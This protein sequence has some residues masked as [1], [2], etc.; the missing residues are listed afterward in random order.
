MIVI[1]FA[2]KGVDISQPCNEFSC[3]KSSYAVDFSITR[4]WL[5]TGYFD[6]A[7][8]TNLNNAKAAGI[9]YND[10]YMFPCRGKSAATQVDDMIADL[11]KGLNGESLNI[12]MPSNDMI[13][14]RGMRAGYTPQQKKDKV[15]L[16]SNNKLVINMTELNNN[17][18]KE[19][20]EWRKGQKGATYGMIWFDIEVNPSSGCG[21]GTSYSSNC[22]Y[23]QQL[24]EAAVAK[25]AKPGVY[26]S[27]YE[28]ETVMGS[29]YACTAAKSYPLWYAHYDNNPSFSDWSS[30]AFGGWTS[31]AI[32]QYQGDVKWCSF[33][34]D[35]DYY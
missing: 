34:V 31:P 30:T 21:W 32:K 1:S 9:P 28:W 20:P 14:A 35:A 23:L 5:S 11:E 15:W 3:L 29:R 17:N 22:D 16:D 13:I 19:I 27:E 2:T 10:V 6:S 7:S 4:A 25:G 12:T 18:N 24:I 8:I 26:S 33:D